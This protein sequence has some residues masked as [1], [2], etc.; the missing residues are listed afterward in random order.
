MPAI[1]QILPVFGNPAL[2][3]LEAEHYVVGVTR[4]LANDWSVK[5][6]L[7][8]K[9][10]SELVVEVQE[11][12]NY[13]N[14]AE[15]DARGVELM[16]SRESAGRWYGWAT[17]SLA[18]TKR[19]NGLTGVTSRFDTD[20]PV[21]ANLVFGYQLTP[22]W[23]VGVRWQYRSGT[24]YTPIIGNEENPD[25]PGFYR[26][27]YGELNTARAA[28]Y[29]RLDLRFERPVRIARAEGVFYIDVVNAYAR[30]NA[31]AATY[32]PVPDSAEYR[33][34]DDD[35]LPFLPSVGVKVKF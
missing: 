5:A 24:P 2:Q 21:I 7:Y 13:V 32:E 8:H 17:L 16:I 33:L 6:E 3:P 34:V 30:T 12:T 9:N 18:R 31:G 20:T 1:V 26:P 29:H 14:G 35:G 4:V 27:V 15:G 23:N 10:L 11:P 22:T 25:Y 19:Y 28:D